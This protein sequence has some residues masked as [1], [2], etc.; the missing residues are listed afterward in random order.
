MAS[1]QKRTSPIKLDHLAAKSDKGSISNR[2]TKVATDNT[3]VMMQTN[4]GRDEFEKQSTANA[5]AQQTS[6]AEAVAKKELEA[7]EEKNKV[8]EQE[9]KA[10]KDLGNFEKE[11]ASAANNAI[12]EM[13]VQA[14][15]AQS[16][17]EPVKINVSALD[18]S[19]NLKLDEVDAASGSG[20]I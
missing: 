13:E 6:A 11:M 2:S 5:V 9:Q 16:R 7:I 17:A 14:A 4:T 10:K 18:K 1:I 15:A 20:C 3:N 19:I 8:G 12:A